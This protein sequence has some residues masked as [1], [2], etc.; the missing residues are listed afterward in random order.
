LLKANELAGGKN[1]QVLQTIKELKQKQESNKQKEIDLSKK[2]IIRKNNKKV[3]KIYS[4]QVL[5][6]KGE[7]LFEN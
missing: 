2:M 5:D 7:D 3:D 4:N 1:S 6:V